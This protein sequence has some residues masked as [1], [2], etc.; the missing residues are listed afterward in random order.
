[1]DVWVPLEQY[2]L[3]VEKMRLELPEPYVCC[4]YKT[5]KAAIQ[6]YA[7]IA[8]FGTLIEDK[9]V[10][11]IPDEDKLGI[12]IDVFPLVSCER[13]DVH[14]KNLY[15]MRKLYQYVFTESTTGSKSLHCIK[16]AL[17]TIFPIS[18]EK[19]LDLMWQ[20][21][22]K[23]TSGRYVT[24]LFVITYGLQFYLKD[25]FGQP[26]LLK[27]EEACLNA[28]SNSRGLLES[29]Y[30]DYLTLPPLEKRKTHLSNVELR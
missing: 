8:D 15:M 28:P 29:I 26:V 18:R 17:K 20:E 1:M 23:V 27:F 16:S 10:C 21:A 9:C 6:P 19:F 5:H 3:F 30:G 25:L 22:S 24:T 14:L 2:H 7:K 11:G 12:N 13:G 4:T